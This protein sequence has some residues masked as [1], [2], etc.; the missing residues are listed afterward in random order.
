M[1]IT[2]PTK[3]KVNH[4][5]VNQYVDALTVAIPPPYINFFKPFHFLASDHLVVL[6]GVSHISLWHKKYNQ[7]SGRKEQRTKEQYEL[8]LTQVQEGWFCDTVHSLVH[9]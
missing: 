9:L 1:T 3:T 7:G 6:I 4:R 8:G 5:E 2:Q